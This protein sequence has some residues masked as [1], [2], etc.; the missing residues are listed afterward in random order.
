VAVP[1]LS[2][3]GVAFS[4]GR[5]DVLCGVDLEIPEGQVAAVLGPN[6][7][8]KTTLIRL[9]AGSL[10]ASR[11]AVRLFGQ[12]LQ[13]LT[14]KQRARAV[15]VVPQESRVLY[16][17]SVREV[18]LMG[19]SPHLGLL[20]LDGPKDRAVAD[21]AMVR[22]GVGELG[23]RAFR[24]LSGG[25]KQRAIVARALTQESRLLLLDEP[26]TFLDLRH[27]LDLYE[28]LIGLARERGRTLV[29]A[30][31]DLNLAARYCD[32]LI[33][34]HAGRIVADGAPERVLLP[35]ILREVYGVEAEVRRDEATGRPF[36]LPR[37]ALTRTG[38]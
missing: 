19:R 27:Q 38:S 33:L 17:F 32:R 8:G 1:A 5:A 30:S 13:A 24:T 10:I 3:E 22:T 9:A 29:L 4:Y 6:G 2:F 26:T 31:H 37:A 11:G 36:V 18:V 7:A 21:E 34:L 16:E 14:P 15:A 20:G 25:E 28:L 35:A 12:P 23:S